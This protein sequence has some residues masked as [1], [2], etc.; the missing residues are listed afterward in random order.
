[1]NSMQPAKDASD[2][3]KKRCRISLQQKV[4]A[5][6]KLQQGESLQSVAAAYDV[7]A[8]TVSKWKKAKESI[9]MRAVT[10]KWPSPPKTAIRPPVGETWPSPPKTAIR[11]SVGEYRTGMFTYCK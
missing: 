3:N 1:M 8:K 9:R 10:E 4:E 5:I 6:E 11:P 7:C 2:P